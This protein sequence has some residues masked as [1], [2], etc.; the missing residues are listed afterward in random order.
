MKLIHAKPSP[1]I[2]SGTMTQTYKC[3]ACNSFTQNPSFSD[4][5]FVEFDGEIKYR[6]IPICSNCGERVERVP[7]LTE[8]LMGIAG[9]QHGV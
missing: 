9:E 3:R 7:A 4:E 8:E 5:S 6:N 2:R 1:H